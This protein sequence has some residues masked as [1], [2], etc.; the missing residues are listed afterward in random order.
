VRT[1][2]CET[3]RLT[4]SVLLASKCTTTSSTVASATLYPYTQFIIKYLCFCRVA[5]MVWC[6]RVTYL[7]C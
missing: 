1:R 2:G 4:R 5:T 3:L 7:L 6:V